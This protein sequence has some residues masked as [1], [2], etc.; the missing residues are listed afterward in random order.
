MLLAGGDKANFFRLNSLLQPDMGGLFPLA[1]EREAWD[2]SDD[3]LTIEDVCRSRR[4]R[5]GGFDVILTNPP[6]A[7]EVRERHVL[8]HYETSRG[9]ARI[10]RDVLFVERC[11]DLLRP[12][13][14]LGIVLPHNKFSA[15]AFA[16]ARRRLLR[17]ARILGVIGLG[18]STFLPHTHQKA[19]V[20]FAQ[21]RT[22]NVRD[23]R[24]AA[25]ERIFFAVSE[26]TGKDSKGRLVLRDGA[27]AGARAWEAAD[28]D[29]EEIV[30]AY[31]RFANDE[32]GWSDGPAPRGAKTAR[33][34]G[35]DLVLVPER[36]DPRRTSLAGSGA[37][38]LL[39]DA[40]EILRTTASPKEADDGAR[41]LVV[42]TSDARE[43]VLSCRKEPVA[44]AG[45][46]STKKVVE[47]GCVLV[48][49]L[50]PYLRQVALA[51][52]GMPGWAGDAWVVCSTEFF[53]LRS[54]NDRSIAFLVP[55]LLS[56]P[57]QAVLAAS[58]EG[59]HHPRFGQDAL[60]DLPVPDSLVE[61]RDD[62]SAKV[63]EAVAMFRRY[64]RLTGNLV[65]DAA[66]AF[67]KP[68]AA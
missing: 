42:D 63:E 23:V 31:H 32:P 20:L 44:L 66:G 36:H 57:V 29:F 68:R 34:L 41:F 53:V 43:G 30:D 15:A 40:A 39:G 37:G 64:E 28:H 17:E 59:G 67:E 24:E 45:L 7:G 47:Q 11:V 13:G 16:S 33:E 50:R 56:G 6:F 35:R 49:R 10:E 27:A 65:K 26:K 58:Q 46:G 8:D 38:T 14:R 2:E 19:C 21:R 51:D 18:R 9:R 1:P 52:G 60:L 54:P 48:S 62:H 22:K 3:A 55:F 4:S 61:R 12:G 5:H 25:D